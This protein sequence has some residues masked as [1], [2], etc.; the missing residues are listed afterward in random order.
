MSNWGGKHEL[1]DLLPGGDRRITYQQA[2]AEA[3][4]LALQDDRVRLFGEGVPD[5]YHFYGTTEGLAEKYPER[6]FDTPV[7]EQVITGVGVG[8]ALGGLRPIVI[9]PRNDF[10]LLALDQLANHAAKWDTM[11]GGKVQCPLTVISVAC[12]G[13]GSAAQHSQALHSTIAQ[14][15]GIDVAVPFTP[16]DAQSAILWSVRESTRPLVVML[17]KW[18]FSLMGRTCAGPNDRERTGIHRTGSDVT[19][20]GISYGTVDCLMAVEPLLEKGISAEVI[21]LRW[22]RPLDIEPIVESVK[23][24]TRLVVVDTGHLS[25]GASGEIVARVAERVQGVRFARVATPD[26]PIPASGEKDF[27]PNPDTVVKAVENLM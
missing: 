26:K 21:D 4:D 14:F 15:P 27:F 17:H 18:L 2:I 3:L 25:F 1:P 24:T 5:Q 8:M 6:V 9:H 22:L 11:T 12:R 16:L 7:A 13:W 10:L 19:L 20:V 23:H